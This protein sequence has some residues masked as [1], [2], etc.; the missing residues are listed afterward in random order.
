MYKLKLLLLILLSINIYAKDIDF[1]KIIKVSKEQN[2][3]I[4]V[5]FHM[6][7]CG[8]CHKLIDESLNDKNIK[9]M[10]NKDFNFISLDVETIGDIIYNNKKIKKLDFARDYEVYFYPTILIFDNNELVVRIK[11][12]RNKDKFKNIINYIAKKAY[13]TMTLNEFIK[14]QEFDK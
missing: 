5:F 14:N 2:K 7:H 3:Q 11:G 4:M 8:W 10:I 6:E 12:Y 9:T 13:K 1:D